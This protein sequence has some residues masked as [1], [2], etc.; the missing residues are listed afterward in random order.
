MNPSQIEEICRKLPKTDLHMHLDGSVRIETIHDLAVQK[1]P[2][3]GWGLAQVE[4]AIRISSDC[5]NL[6]DYLDRFFFINRYLQGAQALGRVA[7]ELCEDLAAENVRY[8]ETR[9]CP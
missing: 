1:E 6:A 9:F 2:E 5:K 4:N 7:F 8:F 3:K